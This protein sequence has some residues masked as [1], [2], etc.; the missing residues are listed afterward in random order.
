MS[1]LRKALPPTLATVAAIAF[2]L[3][4]LLPVIE[5]YRPQNVQAQTS[6]TTPYD[7]NYNFTFTG[8]GTETGQVN[9]NNSRPCI[10]WRIT[11]TTTGLTSATVQ[12]ETSPDNITWT[13]VPN[14]ICSSSVQ[15][16]CV[17]DGANPMPAA[18]QGTVGIKAYGK[19]VRVNVTGVSGSGSGTVI[20]YGNKGASAGGGGGTGAAGPTGATGPAGATG[21]QGPT[22]PAG[23]TGPQGPTGAAGATG[24]TGANGA[25]G[26]TGP[27]GANGGQTASPFPTVTDASPIAWD[28][29][30]ATITNGIVTLDHNTATR[31]LNIS[32]PVNGGFYTLEIRQD[33][34]GGALMTLGSGCGWTVVN[35]GAGAIVLSAAANAVDTLAFYYNGTQC[36]A[37]L[38]N[39]YN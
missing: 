7:C 12:F 13:A 20:I 31:A 26:P 25:T 39:S 21:A 23:A 11:Y 32:N 29:G 16:P 19:Y 30:S 9:N 33:S 37:I 35:Q 1:T 14:T 27:T 6:T 38:N 18:K 24:P 4:G 22:G 2:I 3:Y 34:T 17:Q 28:L 8:T 10:A 36:R 5:I 15:P